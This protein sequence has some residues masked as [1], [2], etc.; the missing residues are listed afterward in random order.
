[1]WGGLTFPIVSIISWTYAFGYMFPKGQAPLSAHLVTIFIPQFIASYVVAFFSPANIMKHAVFMC[2][3][4]YAG[5]LVGIVIHWNDTSPWYYVNQI[6]ICTVAA[7]TSGWS[8]EMRR[9]ITKGDR[10]N[11]V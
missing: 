2:I 5:S 3:F 6:L 4:A 8:E 7:I 11:D 9:M 1:M 10:S